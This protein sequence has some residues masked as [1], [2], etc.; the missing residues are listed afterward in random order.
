MSTVEKVPR[1]NGFRGHQSKLGDQP[2]R[3]TWE[4]TRPEKINGSLRASA[5]VWDCKSSDHIKGCDGNV[6]TLIDFLI[7]GQSV[8][9]WPASQPFQISA[10]CPFKCDPAHILSLNS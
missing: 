5:E 8:R 9:T 6:S 10:S 2:T 7:E 4:A 1:N 3:V